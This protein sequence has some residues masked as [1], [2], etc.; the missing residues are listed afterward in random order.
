VA[1]F[2]ASIFGIGDASG[3][4]GHF[5]LTEA[6]RE[7]SGI[8]CGYRYK[9]LPIRNGAV[10]YPND[11]AEAA[12]DAGPWYIHFDLNALIQSGE[13]VRFAGSVDL[14]DGLRLWP[15]P[16]A[17]ILRL[18]TPRAIPVIYHMELFDVA[19]NPLK[20]WSGQVEFPFAANLNGLPSGV[21]FL[22][23]FADR[24]REVFRIVKT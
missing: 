1:T 6:R 23:I 18:D 2:F 20:S 9:M 15:N 16:V 10:E 8:T 7:Y 22:R 4:L 12:S 3:F 19:G 11:R 14:E 24:Q 21:Y 5:A 13:C 17:D